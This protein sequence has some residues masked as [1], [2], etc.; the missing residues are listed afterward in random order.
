MNEITKRYVI[1]D[2]FLIKIYKSIPLKPYDMYSFLIKKLPYEKTN[3][4]DVNPNDKRHNPDFKHMFDYIDS[5]KNQN[6]NHLL[7]IISIPQCLNTSSSLG[8]FFGKKMNNITK[9]LKIFPFGNTIISNLSLASKRIANHPT[10]IL[11]SLK[12]NKHLHDQHPSNPNPIDINKNTVGY[13]LMENWCNTIC[14]RYINYLQ[15]NGINSCV[16]TR[17]VQSIQPQQPIQP[18]TP[19]Q[20]PTQATQPIQSNIDIKIDLP[21][22][23]ANIENIN[24][25]VEI[26][27]ENSKLIFE[28]KYLSYQETINKM[29]SL[30]FYILENKGVFDESVYSKFDINFLSEVF[31]KDFFLFLGTKN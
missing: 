26:V 21:E 17:F 5:I 25:E 24:K 9:D 6:D 19:T 30:I 31:G 3:E 20:E 23:L 15:I 29:K 13:F 2:N 7:A 10:F 14:K 1:I 11:L 12:G 28:K 4:N 8:N 16:D 18:P 27:K 22:L